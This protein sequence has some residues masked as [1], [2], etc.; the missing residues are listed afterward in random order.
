[1]TEKATTTIINISDKENI[2]K[3]IGYHK[4]Y[5]NMLYKKQYLKYNKVRI[6]NI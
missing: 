5:L 2:Q 4:Y 3:K 6:L 1:M